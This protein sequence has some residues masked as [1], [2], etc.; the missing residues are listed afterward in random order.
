MRVA[1][2]LL[3]LLCCLLSGVCCLLLV[4]CLMFVDRRVK[5]DVRCVLSAV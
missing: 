1:C 3:C 2:C 5:L 4:V